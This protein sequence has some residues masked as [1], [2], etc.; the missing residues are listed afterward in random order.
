MAT[1]LLVIIYMAFIGL[2]L[3]DTLLGVSWPVMHQEFGV[4]E[5]MAG[6]LSLTISVAT[7][8]S[9][10]FSLKVTNKLGT[11]KV[12]ALSVLMTAIGILLVSVMPSIY[13]FFLIAI[14]LGLGA[15]AVDTS[16]NNYVA[17]HFK[18]RHMSWLHALWG[19]GAMTGPVLMS[20]YLAE[21]NWRKGYF[22]VAII[23]LIIA[24]ILWFSLPLWTK[25]EKS[26]GIIPENEEKSPSEKYSL[27][28]AFKE[29]GAKISMLAFLFYC[30]IEM[31]IGLWGS[32]YLINIVK[33]NASKA[34]LWISF[35]FAAITVARAISGVLT[36]RVKNKT[37]LR[38]GQG[39][40][41]LG[42]FLLIFPLPPIMIEFAIILIGIGC[43]PIYPLMI[44]ETPKRFGKNS[45]AVMGLQ[46]ASAYCGFAFIPLGFGY[47][48]SATSF[49]IMPIVLLIFI[50]IVI[51]C[52]E[53]INRLTK[54]NQSLH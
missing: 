38:Y 35:F 39:I 33:I 19:V 11:G 48:A 13:W 10:L 26:R 51:I 36:I 22:C 31:I 30:G 27:T 18:P 23:L 21:G 15:G 1:V 50:V 54:K 28:D 16:L 52:T 5:G 3:P 9:S 7:I 41:A 40:I 46:L 29:D 49:A 8:I 24:E 12:T 43:A 42:A 34:S 47:L 6:I 14:P 45:A 2:G 20:F 53:G 4:D 32:S 37:Q 17:S 25:F 44:H